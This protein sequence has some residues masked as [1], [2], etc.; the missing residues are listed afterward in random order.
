MNSKMLAISV[1]VAIVFTVGLVS[2]VDASNWEEERTFAGDG[3]GT[4][5]VSENP[6]IAER[7]VLRANAYGNFQSPAQTVCGDH[8]CRAGEQPPTLSRFGDYGGYTERKHIDT[9]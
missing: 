4:G 8:I 9:L 5:N 6:A 7:S 2:S 1:L 3:S